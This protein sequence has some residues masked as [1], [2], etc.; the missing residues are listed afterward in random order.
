MASVLAEVGLAAAAD[1]AIAT[2]GADVKLSELAIGIGPFVVGPAVERKIGPAA[3]GHLA[4]DATMWRSADWAKRKGL[5]AELH[6]TPTDMDESIERLSHSLAHSS[7]DAMHELKL[8]LWK[9]TGSL[10]SAAR[11]KSGYQ[12][13]AGAEYAFS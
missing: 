3:F 11:R 7:P 9:G 2:E 4:I 12:R 8:V 6:S 10:G 5:F 1:Y 13:E